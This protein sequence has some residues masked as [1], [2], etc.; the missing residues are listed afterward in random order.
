[1]IPGALVGV[2]AVMALLLARPSAPTATAVRAT[3]PVTPAAAAEPAAMSANH[4]AAV[5]ELPSDEGAAAQAGGTMPR[6]VVRADLVLPGVTVPRTPLTP[7]K[8]RPPDPAPAVTVPPGCDG[9][10]ERLVSV[11]TAD[12]LRAALADARP[13]DRIVL[14]DGTY[15]GRFKVTA[16]GRADRR[17]ALCGTRAAVL[18]G[19]SDRYGYVLALTASHWDIR[20]LGITNGQKGV[21]L[22]RASFNQLV[23]LEVHSIGDEAVHFRSGSRGN[24]LASS[25]PPHGPA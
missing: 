4:T 7:S 20:G 5:P 23:D 8:G 14:A 16:S 25:D 22:D 3:V 13:G 10:A 18:D 17:V 21:V 9:P 2:V 15:V 1:V 12:G 6:R 24:R 19:G 11:R